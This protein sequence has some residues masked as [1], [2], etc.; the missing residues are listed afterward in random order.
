MHP[1]FFTTTCSCVGGRRYRSNDPYFS[2]E[3]RKAKPPNAIASKDKV[4]P[5]SGTGAKDARKIKLSI[6]FFSFLPSYFSLERRKAKPPNAIASK[7]KVVPLSGTAAIH[8]KMI[9][10]SI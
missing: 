7:D 6:G 5:L 10:L 8:P 4:V 3:R 9:K 2:L 1:A